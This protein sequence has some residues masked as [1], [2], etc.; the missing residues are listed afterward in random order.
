[1]IVGQGRDGSMAVMEGWEVVS[2]R[3]LDEFRISIPN[4]LKVVLT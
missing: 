1:M 2:L 4:T 3:M